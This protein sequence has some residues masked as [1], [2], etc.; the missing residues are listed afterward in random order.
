VKQHNEVE[1]VLVTPEIAHDWLGYNTHNRRLRDRVVIAYATDIKA[2]AW[3][4][5]GE[6]I[7]FAADG[8][9][10]DGQ[11]RLAAVIAAD[12]PVQML[13]VRGLPNETQD[14]VDGGAK[15][16]F[17]DVL[18]LRGEMNYSTLAALLRRI[19][20]W[21]SGVRKAGSNTTPTNAQ[22]LQVLEK[23][24]EARDAAR[25]GN[26]IST[27]CGLPG[28]I[29]ALGHWLFGQLDSDDAAHFFDRLHDGQN[30]A[31][32]DPIY[33]LRRTVEASR[34]VRGERSTT[35]LTAIMIKAWNAYRDGR[36]IDL[37]R[38]RPGGAQPERF[39]EPH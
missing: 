24:P 33:E 10:L 32:G 4:W 9:L 3:Q 35:Y 14:T 5:N 29:C 16:K 38:F 15:R 22:L 23:Y 20:L 12:I 27:G 17:S 30:L 31:K 1:T 34:T 11:H 26:H 25:I 28:S 2:G 37:L 36:T 6:S 39:P 19:A 7:K 8:K 21:E 18:Q 13:V